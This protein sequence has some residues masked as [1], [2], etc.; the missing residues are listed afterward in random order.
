MADLTIE[1]WAEFV[2]GGV[3]D[4]DTPTS[5]LEVSMGL[6]PTPMHASVATGRALHSN[7]DLGVDLI[8]TP[9]G[10]GFVPHTHPGDHL[11]IVVAGHGT[12]T[13]D[14]KVYATKAGQVYM[15]EGAVPH[16]VGGVTEHLI[17][18]V[19]APHKAVDSTDRMV[20]VDYSSVLAMGDMTCT[21]C[22]VTAHLPVLLHEL[23]CAHCPGPCCVTTGDPDLDARLKA[24]LVRDLAS[25]MTVPDLKPGMDLT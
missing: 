21:I 13:F 11:L 1:T 6:L 19:G 2:G 4:G 23:D 5:M 14:G 16:A 24:D 10:G 22:E 7:G 15:V 9:A 17:L 12:I 8:R 18:A 25:V 3:I 20:P